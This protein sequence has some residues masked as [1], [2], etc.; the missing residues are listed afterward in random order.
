LLTRSRM[1]EG[2]AYA[3]H[4][5]NFP[6]NTLS[7]TYPRSLALRHNPTRP[8]AACKGA[9]LLA[10]SFACGRE[11]A[12]PPAISARLEIPAGRDWTTLAW[13][14]GSTPAPNA[15]CTGGWW[16]HGSKDGPP[17][18]RLLNGFDYR[19]GRCE[20]VAK[21]WHC[22][23]AAKAASEI[24]R[25]EREAPPS[26]PLFVSAADSAFQSR[27]FMVRV[28]MPYLKL[29]SRASPRA[30]PGTQVRNNNRRLKVRASALLQ[31]EDKIQKSREHCRNGGSPFV[32]SLGDK[33]F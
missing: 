12:G 14:R 24:E 27:T 17:S 16:V 30:R 3:A 2:A 1:T 5:L 22:H 4:P 18:F 8:A 32:L 19:F 7:Q 6:P 28:R 13:C 20:V 33:Q 9:K 26:R 23:G 31:P 29:S 11:S 10:W 21:T 15:R 25:Q